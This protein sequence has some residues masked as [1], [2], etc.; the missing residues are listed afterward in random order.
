MKIGNL[1]VNWPP[2]GERDGIWADS[3]HGRPGITGDLR[4]AKGG[5]CYASRIKISQPASPRKV[6][7]KFR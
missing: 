7:V 5:D 6:Q 2:I 3:Q 4:I 1:A